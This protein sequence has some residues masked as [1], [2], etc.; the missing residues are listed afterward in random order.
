[1]FF[2]TATLLAL[3][4]WFGSIVFQSA[5]VA[6]VVFTALDADGARRVLR[7]LFPRFFRLGI[8]C[9]LVAFAGLVFTPGAFDRPVLPG[10]VGAML[11]ANA[12]A[13]AVVPAT[14]AARDAG[15]AGE[16]RFRALHRLSVGLTLAVLV[17]IVAVVS[18]ITGG[19]A[20]TGS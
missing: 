6:P 10:L 15:E 4:C 17:G 2:L 7:T 5:I 9:G 12:V 13:L 1:M 19:L 18:I 16:A 20:E 8:A 11:I 14:N 3:G